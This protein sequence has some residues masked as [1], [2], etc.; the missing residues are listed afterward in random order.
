M[1]C[2]GGRGLT[3]YVGGGC[4]DERAKKGLDKGKGEGKLKDGFFSLCFHILLLFF[5]LSFS[6]QVY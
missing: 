1:G 2:W 3:A 4:Q 5:G 6:M